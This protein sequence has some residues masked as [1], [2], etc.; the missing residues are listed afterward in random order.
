MK[1]FLINKYKIRIF[2]YLIPILIVSLTINVFAAGFIEAN[3]STYY[4]NDNNSFAV[5]CWRWIDDNNDTVAECYRFGAD[6]KLL[7]NATM[8]DGKLTNDKGQW[9]EDGI[10]QRVYT[11]N[12]RPLLSNKKNQV[13]VLSAT[14]SSIT[15]INATGKDI[16]DFDREKKEPKY[17]TSVFSPSEVGYI[18]GKKVDL[19]RPE[20]GDSTGK[21]IGSDL[22]TEDD[23]KYLEEGDSVYGGVDM[24]KYVTTSNK[25]TKNVDEAK[26]WGGDVWNGVMCLSGNGASVK[27][28]VSKYEFFHMEIAHQ[29]HGTSTADTQCSLEL[30]IGGD[31]IRGYSNFNDGPPEIIDEWLEEQGSNTIELKLVVEGNAKGRKVYIRNA[32]MRY[33]RDAYKAKKK[34]K[35]A[36]EL[37]EKK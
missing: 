3:G 18:L 13:N 8:S 7:K 4:V 20:G 26:I 21:I 11:L 10:V 32:R 5:N 6:G 23:P 25:L 24:S 27:F 29:T 35:R 1:I 33:I 19:K 12:F 2:K 34:T 36:D 28:D 37:T 9:I 31:F 16:P 17:P 22:L 15:R 14:N 30:Y